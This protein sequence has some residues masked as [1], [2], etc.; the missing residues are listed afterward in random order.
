MKDVK[1]NDSGG[2]FLWGVTKCPFPISSILPTTHA[3]GGVVFRKEEKEIRKA[4]L[5]GSNPIEE[6]DPHPPTLCGSYTSQRD[7]RLGCRAPFLNP[8]YIKSY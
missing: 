8:S 1:E 3:K 5:V 4:T 7:P 2:S 6:Y